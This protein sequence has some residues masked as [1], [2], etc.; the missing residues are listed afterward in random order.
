M[1]FGTREAGGPRGEVLREGARAV[2]LLNV[3]L[4]LHP[5]RHR[6]G[7]ATQQR[8][9][10]PP[11]DAQVDPWPEL[12]GSGVVPPEGGF[13]GGLE[14]VFSGF[15]M[16]LYVFS[17]VFQSSRYL[18]GAA[19]VR[20]DRTFVLELWAV[21]SLCRFYVREQRRPNGDQQ[22]HRRQ[23]LYR[24]VGCVVSLLSYLCLDSKTS[25]IGWIIH[26]TE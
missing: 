4:L 13:W 9:L 25:R 22:A 18:R 8:G 20:D 3:A 24:T 23:P 2:G 10:G 14:A 15:K 7:S 6:G 26:K 19:V 12:P 17:C 1:L 16:C 21:I 5:H 11:G